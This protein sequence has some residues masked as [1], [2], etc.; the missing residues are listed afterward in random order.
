MHSMM[1]QNSLRSLLH[2]SEGLYSLLPNRSRAEQSSV[3][4]TSQ[5]LLVYLN[6]LALSLRMVGQEAEDLHTSPE[7]QEAK[8]VL[9][10]LA[11]LMISLPSFDRNLPGVYRSIAEL[12]RKSGDQ[13]G[14]STPLSVTVC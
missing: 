4:Q 14:V 5:T 6:Q 7:L 11:S 10:Q 3:V 13:E 9:E 1:L 2:R 8:Q 12:C